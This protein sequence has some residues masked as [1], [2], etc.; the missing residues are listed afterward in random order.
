MI[1][2]YILGAQNKNLHPEFLIN[3][4]FIVLFISLFIFRS[5]NIRHMYLA[6][7]L[8]LLAVFASVFGLNNF[9]YISSSLSL[10]L[11][12]LGIINMLLF[13]KEEA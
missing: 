10:G 6:F 2:F 12:I 1:V 9:L 3:F 4:I 13:K 11:L 8:L 7:A 5:G